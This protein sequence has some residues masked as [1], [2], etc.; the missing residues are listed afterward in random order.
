M[1]VKPPAPHSSFREACT[2]L[3]DKGDWY[4]LYRTAMQWRVAGG[5]MWTP[6]AWLM[7]ICS[8]LL[9]KQPKTAVHCCDMALTTWIDRP[10]DRR[11]LQYVRGVLV[12]D[13]VGDPI[14]AL[15]DLAAATDGPE[16]L[17]ELAAGDL[18]HGQELAARSRVRAPR[19][20]PSPDFTGEHRSEAAPPE[21]PVPADGAIPPL[22]NIALPH[23]RSTA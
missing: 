1:R 17:A 23:I 8:A 6:D 10:L 21:Q 7:D 11:V 3:L 5:G 16:W 2:A 4:G 9:H 22:W 18:K 13:H 15:D 14:R 20:G 19:V 12:C